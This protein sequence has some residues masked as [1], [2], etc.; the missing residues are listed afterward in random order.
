MPLEI[1]LIYSI[2]NIDKIMNTYSPQG[3]KS[4]SKNKITYGLQE[5]SWSQ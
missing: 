4:K 1:L 5:L 2:V 3:E